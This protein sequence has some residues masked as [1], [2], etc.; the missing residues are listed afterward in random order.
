MNVYI[1][2]NPRQ[3]RWW[4]H[5]DIWMVSFRSIDEATAFVDRLNTRL[6]APH[7]LAMIASYPL[8]PGKFINRDLHDP[9][10]PSGSAT[11]VSEVRNA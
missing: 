11:P 1:E 3:N 2:N 10:A 7:S 9:I 6:N 4:V 8:V 5:L